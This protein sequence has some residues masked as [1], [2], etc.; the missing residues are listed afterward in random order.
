MKISG[1][2]HGDEHYHGGTAQATWNES[3]A[4]YSW[5]QQPRLFLKSM[6]TLHNGGLWIIP[7]FQCKKAQWNYKH[8]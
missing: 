1:S 2:K 6:Q 3:S 7:Y 4:S 8:V 5:K